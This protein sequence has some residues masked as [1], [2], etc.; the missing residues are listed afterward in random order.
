M[1]KCYC[2]VS[3]HPLFRQITKNKRKHMQVLMYFVAHY[4][5]EKQLLSSILCRFKKIKEPWREE[6]TIR[7]TEIKIIITCICFKRKIYRSKT[8]QKLQVFLFL[9][10]EKKKWNFIATNDN[11]TESGKSSKCVC[12]LLSPTTS[13]VFQS[14]VGGSPV[15]RNRMFFHKIKV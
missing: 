8:K 12:L 3:M 14:F 4:D 7:K 2:F 1:I 9:L 5:E 11:G 6:K 10:F 15:N 13:G